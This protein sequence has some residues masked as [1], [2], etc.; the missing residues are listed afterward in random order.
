VLHKDKIDGFSNLPLAGPTVVPMRG[1]NQTLQAGDEEFAARDAFAIVDV[2]GITEE[3][4]TSDS[5]QE[6]IEKT[7][8]VN[9]AV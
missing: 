4:A 6:L 5:G 9:E 2:L 8:S 1:G 3:Q 7:L